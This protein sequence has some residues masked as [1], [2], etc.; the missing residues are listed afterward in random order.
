MDINGGVNVMYFEGFNNGV[1]RKGRGSRK[2]RTFPTER[3]RRVH[4]NDRIFE[5]K[6]L[7][8]NPTK[9]GKA[10]I[11]QDGIVYINELR[12]LV[13]ELKSLVEKKR[14]GG[15]HK[16]IDSR[17][18][19]YVTGEIEHPFSKMRLNHD[20]ENMEKKPES[21][22]IDQCSWLERNSKVIQVYVRVI[23]DEVTIKVVQKKKINC[24][25]FCLQSA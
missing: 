8:P 5:L 12:R 11:V 21:D 6:N 3:E 13:S 15:R 19:I 7:I 1:T 22:M 18:T 4:F 17:N 23:D 2:S 10:S 16:N 9:G 14:C 24:L 20:E 25:F